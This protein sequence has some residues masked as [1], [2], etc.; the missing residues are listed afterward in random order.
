MRAAMSATANTVQRARSKHARVGRDGINARLP[1]NSSPSHVIG[2]HGCRGG[3]RCP[4]QRSNDLNRV[5]PDCRRNI[6][7][8]DDVETTLTALVFGN[9][10]L[11]F[12][13]ALSHILLGQ[14]MRFALLDQELPEQSMAW[15]PQGSRHA[16]RVG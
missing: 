5:S 3:R 13:Q 2:S 11:R 9:E 1:M 16:G 6:D 8:L 15:R 12:A 10:A 7:K 4:D 14:T